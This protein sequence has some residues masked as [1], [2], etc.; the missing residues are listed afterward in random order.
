VIGGS[1]LLAFGAAS[2]AL[3]LQISSGFYDGWALSLVSLAAV[4]AVL[5]ALRRRRG[6]GEG[7]AVLGQALLGAGSVAGLA[8]D[9]F[10]NPIPGADPLAFQGGFRWLAA[11]SLVVLS[12]Y[13]C[14]HLRASLIR[15][16]F[17]L[18]LLCFAVMGIAVLR[19]VP[20][21]PLRYALLALLLAG[22]W[23]L[24]RAW[25]GNAGE[26]AAALALLQPRALSVLAQGSGE[27]VV[28]FCFALSAYAI[29]RGA[30]EVLIG[31]AL[32]T[33]AASA[34]YALL[35][36]I[37]LLFGLPLRRAL[38]LSGLVAIAVLVPLLAGGAGVL[39]RELLDLQS[40]D[41]LAGE[42]LSLSPLGARLFGMEPVAGV[43]LA[44]GAGVLALSLRRQ[45]GLPL[46]C[47]AAGAAWAVALLPGGHSFA[48]SWWLC[49]A[50]L[51]GAA[52]AAPVRIEVAE[53]DRR[54]GTLASAA[55]AG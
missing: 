11:I 4:A 33:L 39:G 21:D 42:P 32:A 30:Q 48:G 12:A 53:G 19:V 18:L 3:A 54:A 16:R 13:L 41:A 51:A 34:P 8:F 29:A 10:A 55:R 2:V 9:L 20:G 46:A 28:F 43:G 24:T 15:A 52:A 1:T 31:C 35:F 38:W 17:L 25:P 47:A 23:L 44:L 36:A 49:S 50:L 5:A 27:L 37:P 26:L 6:A 40:S 7:S 22:S 45:T 14:I